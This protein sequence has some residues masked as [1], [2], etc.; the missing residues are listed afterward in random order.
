[1]SNNGAEDVM[2]VDFNLELIAAINDFNDAVLM[3]KECCNSSDAVDRMVGSFTNM[4]DMK[5][6]NKVDT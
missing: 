2:C 1:M 3:R 4:C 5:L 6:S